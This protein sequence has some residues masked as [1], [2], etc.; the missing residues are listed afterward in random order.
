MGAA[1]ERERARFIIRREHNLVDG[2]SA[3]RKGASCPSQHT[4]LG[5]Q[6]V[7]GHRAIEQVAVVQDPG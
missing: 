4:K 7:A 3:I 5:E 2:A 1:G 6:R